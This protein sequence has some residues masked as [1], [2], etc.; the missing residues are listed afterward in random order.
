MKILQTMST[1]RAIKAALFLVLLAVLPSTVMAEKVNLNTANAE[2]IQYI[3]GIGLSKARQIVQEREKLGK[4]TDMEQVDAVPG[5]GERTMIDVIKYGSL[6]SGVSELTDE[7]KA[8]QPLRSAVNPA[9][10][11]SKLSG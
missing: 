5:I 11:A 2:A 10:P 4:F 9:I 1:G 6:D 7:M 8:N 3:P